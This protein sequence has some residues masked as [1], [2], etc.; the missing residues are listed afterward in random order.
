MDANTVYQ[1]HQQLLVPLPCHMLVNLG[2]MHM[3]FCVAIPNLLLSLKMKHH[4]NK[5]PLIYF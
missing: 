2:H 5:C 4:A 3:C 1:I